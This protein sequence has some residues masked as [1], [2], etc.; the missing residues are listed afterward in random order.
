MIIIAASIPTLR[1]LGRQI[2]DL[3]KYGLY[4]KKPNSII[5]GDDSRRS[6]NSRKAGYL[7][8]KDDFPDT[9]MELDTIV[10]PG[11]DAKSNFHDE[12]V[13]SGWTTLSTQGR[14]EGNER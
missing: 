4:G 11:S 6:G 10:S 7:R 2:V 13:N 3:F 9:S 14:M 8:Q 12:T 1:P 5:T